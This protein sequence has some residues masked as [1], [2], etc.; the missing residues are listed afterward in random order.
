M[1]GQVLGLVFELEGRSQGGR[2]C[3][4]VCVCYVIE[5]VVV[6][7]AGCWGGCGFGLV[8]ASAQLLGAVRL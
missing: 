4:C 8:S 7:K 1:L 6:R 5:G 2:W 3:V